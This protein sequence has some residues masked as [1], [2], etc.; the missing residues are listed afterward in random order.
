[1]EP[2]I[3]VA[4]LGFFGVMVTSIIG[5]IVAMGTNRKEKQNVAETTIEKTL[6]ERILLRD[7]QLEE[8]EDDNRKLVAENAALFAKLEMCKEAIEKLKEGRVD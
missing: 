3:L 5:A 2:S 7:E 1:M 8:S 6:R 4:V